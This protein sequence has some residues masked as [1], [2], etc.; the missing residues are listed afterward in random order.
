MGVLT[1]TEAATGHHRSY[2]RNYT[3]IFYNGRNK[4]VSVK[5]PEHIVEQLDRYANMF[6]F[7]NRSD[8]IRLII[9]LFLHV[10]GTSEEIDPD[11]YEKGITI[12][13]EAST[14]D[15]LVVRETFDLR[16]GMPHSSILFSKVEI[17]RA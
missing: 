4:V 2:H 16:A 8:L 1:G 14:E 12:T 9:N 10:L 15:G 13:I 7:K 6:A 3:V 17:R 5:M 11:F